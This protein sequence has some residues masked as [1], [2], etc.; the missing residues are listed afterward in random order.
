M[1]EPTMTM[2]YSDPKRATDPHSLPDL[3]VWQDDEATCLNL[4]CDWSGPACMA[5]DLA[6]ARRALPTPL[7]WRLACRVTTSISQPSIL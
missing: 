3:E 1:E 7:R 4:T 2:H 5:A 6:A